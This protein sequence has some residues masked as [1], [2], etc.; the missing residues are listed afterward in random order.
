[1][2]GKVWINIE[3][4]M[5]FLS[6]ENGICFSRPINGKVWQSVC[7][8]NF[9]S[10]DS[11]CSAVSTFDASVMWLSGQILCLFSA[12][13]CQGVLSSAWSSGLESK[14]PQ[15][16]PP[17][18]GTSANEMVPTLNCL[19][20]PNQR[21]VIMEGGVRGD[22]GQQAEETTF[23]RIA[24]IWHKTEVVC[25]HGLSAS[26]LRNQLLPFQQQYM[27]TGKCRG[28]AA[29]WTADA[30]A[31]KTNARQLRS[32]SRPS[33][34]HLAGSRQKLGGRQ[35]SALLL[36]L[37]L[38]LQGSGVRHEWIWTLKCLCLWKGS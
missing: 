16:L 5:S 8:E 1:M 28:G 37:A 6:S 22:Y 38:E 25:M 29:A 9:L 35:T 2:K 19:K 21:M 17:V 36:R 24:S 26:P 12:V 10:S 34:H 32:I 33:H 18:K 27:E 13:R 30:A 23:H 31:N 15:L 7:D 3:Y 11:S 20:G 4:W 14:A